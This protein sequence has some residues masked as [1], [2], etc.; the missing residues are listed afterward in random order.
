MFVYAVNISG[1]PQ[2]DDAF[3]IMQAQ[4]N[5]TKAEFDEAIAGRTRIVVADPTRDGEMFFD[6]E[7]KKLGKSFTALSRAGLFFTVLRKRHDGNFKAVADY[8]ISLK[9]GRKAWREERLRVEAAGESLESFACKEASSEDMEV[10]RPLFP[11]SFKTYLEDT[12]TGVLKGSEMM[13]AVFP[14]LKRS[15][16]RKIFHEMQMHYE[17]RAAKWKSRFGC[18]W[19]SAYFLMAVLVTFAIYEWLVGSFEWHG[20]LAA[21]TALIL[22]IIPIVGSTLASI[23]AVKLW[24]WPAWLAFATF[25]WYYLPAVYLIGQLVAAAFKGEGKAAWNKLIGKKEDED[26]DE[27]A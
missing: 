22:S 3:N 21:P 10:L 13:Q 5:L 12:E 19:V 23:A 7:L 27:E 8:T 15:D 14:S 25:F 17:K 16:C 26:D 20:L 6:R 4:F 24:E 9:V 18:V 11:E 1:L 2:D